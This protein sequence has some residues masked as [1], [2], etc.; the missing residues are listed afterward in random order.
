MNRQQRARFDRFFDDRYDAIVAA[1]DRAYPGEGARRAH[2]SLATAYRFW[3]KVE[4]DGD[5]E[6]WVL[7]DASAPGPTVECWVA[8]PPVADPPVADPPVADPPVDASA[9]DHRDA[10]D[11]ERALVVRAARWRRA[12][13]SVVLSA[14]A[15]VLIA[16]EL[17]VAGR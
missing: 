10:L 12:A 2:S 1:L 15:L 16:A 8:D 17:F 5:P 13:A 14:L 7:R 6:F 3:G 4:L 9:P 11:R